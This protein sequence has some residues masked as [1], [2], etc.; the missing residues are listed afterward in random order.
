MVTMAT[1]KPRPE[2]A[3]PARHV[4]SERF[5]DRDLVDRIF[6]YVLEQ[7]PEMAPRAEEVKAAIRVEFQG[8][9]TYVRG[10]ARGE[11]ARQVLSIFNGRNAREVARR[12]NIGRSTVYRI[13]KQAGSSE[14]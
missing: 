5:A 11:L 7:L 6:D 3:L 14:R 8:E 2:A 10:R 1:K 4:I 12:L 13:I 9:E